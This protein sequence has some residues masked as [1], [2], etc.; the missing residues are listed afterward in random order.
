LREVQPD[1]VI[2]AL[3]ER[4]G[5]MP[6]QHLLDARLDG[7]VVENGVRVYE[8]LTASGPSSR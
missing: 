3:T 4:R 5:R 7:V 2:V 8:R 1:R 6:V